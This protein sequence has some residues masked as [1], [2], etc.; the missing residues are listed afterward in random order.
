MFTHV[1]F[2]KMVEKINKKQKNVKGGANN[3]K[4]K[5]RNKYI[6]FSRATV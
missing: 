3:G 4:P 5:L 1:E 2:M 6:V